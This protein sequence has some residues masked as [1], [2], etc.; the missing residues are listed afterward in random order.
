[1]KIEIWSDFIC[2]FCYI[3]K[4]RF[5]AALEKFPHYKSVF[6]E[7]KSYELDPGADQYTK[8]NMYE[9][10]GNKYNMTIEEIK[11]SITNLTEQA[12]EIG[13]IYN[14]EHIQRTNTFDAHRL[15]QYAT[16]QNKSDKMI[17]QLFKAHLTE[18]KHIDEHH[19]LI[20]L[21][22]EIGLDIEE[23]ETLL[24]SCKYT[25]S[26]R[27]DQEQ[28]EE[29]GIQDVPFFVINEKYAISGAQ[30]VEVFLDVLEQ[31]WEEENEQPI[32]EDLQPKGVGAT[33]CCE[34]DSCSRE[35]VEIK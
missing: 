24:A 34:G 27:S 15:A 12:A 11:T 33:Y 18:S 17:E 5:E 6:T 7:Y 14:F 23:V 31:V 13:I 1:M 16:R 20:E 19:T 28:A 8:W 4:R 30:P 3:G 2:P 29:I 26:V 10:L 22:R 21:A 32:R 9:L 35:E 25:K